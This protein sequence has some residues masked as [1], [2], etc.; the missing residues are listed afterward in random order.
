MAGSMMSEERG[1][2]S[3]LERRASVSYEGRL[4]EPDGTT[5]AM[6]IS[7]SRVERTCA[8]SDGGPGRKRGEHS[9]GR[10]TLG[11]GG[12]EVRSARRKTTEKEI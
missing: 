10:S 3:E 1:R 7:R 5:D 4:S 12:A 2:T 11:T 6:R 9:A 8:S